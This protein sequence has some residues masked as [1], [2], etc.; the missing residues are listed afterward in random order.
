VEAKIININ[1][2][3]DAE[4]K[5]YQNL[6]SNSFSSSDRRSVL[7]FKKDLESILLS[8][9]EEEGMLK[10]KEFYRLYHEIRKIYKTT[11]NLRTQKK[12]QQILMSVCQSFFRNY[13]DDHAVQAIE[14]LFQF[15]DFYK[16]YFLSYTSRKDGYGKI[17]SNI[18]YKKP[19]SEITATPVTDVAKDIKNDWL[20]NIITTEMKDLN[21]YDYIEYTENNENIEEKYISGI[22]NS[23]SFIQVIKCSIFEGEE[24]STCYKEFKHAMSK[25]KGSIQKNIAYIIIEDIEDIK[26]VEPSRLDKDRYDWFRHVMYNG[27]D[28]VKFLEGRNDHEILRKKIKKLKEIIEGCRK[29]YILSLLETNDN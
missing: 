10:K 18:T 28:S 5:V 22:R 20:I 1:R 11:K 3:K 14:K 25:Y 2:I 7:D 4:N 6:Y 23:F 9:K 29:R 13:W 15:A 8:I 24:I 21:G 12:A 19:I 17:K 16:D 26:Q 27:V